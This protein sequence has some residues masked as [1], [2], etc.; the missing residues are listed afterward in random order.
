[1]LNNIYLPIKLL[2]SSTETEK[3]LKSAITGGAR[4]RKYRGA[5][6]KIDSISRR[7]LSDKFN[8]GLSQSILEDVHMGILRRQIPTWMLPMMIMVFFIP[9]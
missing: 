4:S 5:R 9:P 3:D 6:G 7:H 8:K 1:M 2:R